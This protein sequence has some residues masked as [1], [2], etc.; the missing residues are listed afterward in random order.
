MEYMGGRKWG[1]TETRHKVGLKT[2]RPVLEEPMTIIAVAGLAMSGVSM[3]QQMG[4]ADD[5]REAESR[6][7]AAQ[8]KMNESQQRQSD[9]EAQR[10]RVAQ[11]REERIKRAQVLAS[12]GNTSMGIS[13]TSSLQGSTGSLGTQMGA[14]IGYINQQQGFATEQSGYN[15]EMGA[16]SSS[17]FTAQNSAAGWQ[18][19]GSLGGSLFSA[20]GG[21]ST[22]FGKKTATT[23]TA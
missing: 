5:M 7:M 19:I 2:G 1:R 8:T 17:I 13:G 12:T 10:Q 6:R 22:I 3:M 9:V 11:V 18:Q 15:Q 4:A 20:G 23:A 16:A 14:N 21:F